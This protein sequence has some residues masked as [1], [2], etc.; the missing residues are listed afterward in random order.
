MAHQFICE[1]DSDAAFTLASEALPLAPHPGR[2]REDISK[3]LAR[4]QKLGLDPQTTGRPPNLAV[5]PG[6]QST[7]HQT[8]RSTSINIARRRR[9]LSLVGAIVGAGLIAIPIVTNVVKIP[10][11][12]PCVGCGVTR[13]QAAPDSLDNLLAGLPLAAP[14]QQGMQRTE[15]SSAATSKDLGSGRRLLPPE[16]LQPGTSLPGRRPSSAISG[17]AGLGDELRS[18]TSQ[19]VLPYPRRPLSLPNGTELIGPTV[20]NWLGQL[21]I[22]NNSDQDALVK[23]KTA[24]TPRMTARAVYVSARETVTLHKIQPKEYVLQFSTGRDFDASNNTFRANPTFSEFETMLLYAEDRI[25]PATTEY[26]VHKIT[27]HAVPDG[28][29]HAKTITAGDFADVSSGH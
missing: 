5:S 7:P 29:V 1:C 25:D 21:E 8:T 12:Q 3:Q 15:Y 24:T 6:A 20:G 10:P 16:A 27:L 17:S 23:L 18:K 14:A 22:R 19:P 28:N 4:G 13:P 2:L 11:S 26:A 9:R